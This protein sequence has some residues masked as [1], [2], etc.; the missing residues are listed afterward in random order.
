MLVTQMLFTMLFKMLF[1]WQPRKTSAV[2]SGY[3][4]AH[5]EDVSLRLETGGGTKL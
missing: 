4:L 3:F 2:F 1:K 5:P